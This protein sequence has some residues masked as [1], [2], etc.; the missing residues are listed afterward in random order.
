MPAG[1]PVGGNGAHSGGRV[2]GERA[3]TLGVADGVD[4]LYAPP[5]EQAARAALLNAKVLGADV[6]WHRWL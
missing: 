6:D 2:P 5:G 3:A 1:P 4:A